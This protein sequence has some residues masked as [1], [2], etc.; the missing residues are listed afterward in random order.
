MEMMWNAKRKHLMEHLTITEDNRQQIDNI[1]KYYGVGCG[2]VA[3]PA[4][5]EVEGRRLLGLLAGTRVMQI[6]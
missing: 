5:G 3:Q 4:E 2:F 6:K 1:I